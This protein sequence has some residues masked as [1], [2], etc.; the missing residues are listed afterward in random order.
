MSLTPA[1]IRAARGLLDWTAKDLADRI[2]IKPSSMSAIENGKAKGSMQ[3]I[4]A[5]ESHLARSGIEF[6]GTDGV[7]LRQLDVQVF[8]GKE[9]FEDFMDDVYETARDAGGDISLFNSIPRLWHE[10]LGKDWYD[11]HSKRMAALGD[12]IN[13]RITLQETE[14]VTI[15]GTAAHR[16]FPRSLAKNKIFYA[17]GPKLAFLDFHDKQLKI[18]VITHP[19]FANIFR[20]L[21]DVAWDE[22]A[23][24]LPQGKIA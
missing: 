15:L 7:R 13:V 1:Q 17:Y 21:Y 6:L 12:K 18:T 16:R 19:D 2:G 3:T 5:I 24:E 10:W 4:E 22:I 14:N 20:A 8:Q 11:M 23:E 9:G